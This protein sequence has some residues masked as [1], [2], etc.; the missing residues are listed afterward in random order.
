MVSVIGILTALLIPAVQGA[1]EAA[2]RASCANNLRQVGLALQTY[3][4][5]AGSFP[6]VNPGWLNPVLGSQ[7]AV[8][9]YSPLV[10][11]LS[12]LELA[13]LFNSVNFFAWPV[14]GAAMDAN[15]T[16]MKTSVS[17][18]LCPSDAESPVAGYGRVSYRFS[19]GPTPF[20]AP[21]WDDPPSFAGAFTVWKTY[22]PADFADGLSN[23]IG[24]SERLQGDWTRGPY[25]R[26]GDYMTSTQPLRVPPPSSDSAVSLCD[27]LPLTATPVD[28]RGGE[29]WFLS[30]LPFTNYNHCSAPNSLHPDCSFGFSTDSLPDRLLR[31]GVFAATSYHPGGVNVLSMDGSAHFMRDSV[32]LRT[33]RTV[34]TRSGGEVARVE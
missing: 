27:A 8:S 15:G 32:E 28:S 6:P 4:S 3:L 31:D 25:K 13:P 9:S 18:F 21:V 23:T 11:L 30:A 20:H 7:V 17:V 19:L 1:R 34:S 22:R 33:W 5:S 10:H 26:G 29:T 12:E 2:R 14:V 24:V 16:A